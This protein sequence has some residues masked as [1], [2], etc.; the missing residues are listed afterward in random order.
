M[1]EVTHVCSCALV[2]GL[3]GGQAH[4][5]GVGQ[6]DET[7]PDLKSPLVTDLGR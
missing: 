3:G 5:L 4:E 6:A 7:R 2:C 1:A